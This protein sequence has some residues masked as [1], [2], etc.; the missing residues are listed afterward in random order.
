MED[1][2]WRAFTER[3]HGLIGRLAVPGPFTIEAL[4][5]AVARRRGRPLRLIP[6][7]GT[8]SGGSGICGVWIAF[9]EADHVYYSV[10]TSP[11]HQAHIVL[12]ELAHIL[13]EHRQDGAPDHASLRRL[14]PDLDPAMAAR[15]LARDRTRA[16]T[17]QEQEAELLASL[18][19]QHF[20]T[21]PA[22]RP[23][24]SRASADTL[25]LVMCTFAEVYEWRGPTA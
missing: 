8:D 3:C 21:L 15:L 13:L 6:L 2:Q 10:V 4:A 19:W 22:T 25:S 14:F 9:A 17:D 20:D 11:V 5:E 7:A 23:G 1:R 18:M 16:T 24:A 12:H